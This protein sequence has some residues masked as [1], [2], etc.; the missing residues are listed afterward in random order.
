MNFRKQC[1]WETEIHG[2]GYIYENADTLTQF[3]VSLDEF[4]SW[5]EFDK[6]GTC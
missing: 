2:P 5:D 6:W 4:D 1:P 3:F